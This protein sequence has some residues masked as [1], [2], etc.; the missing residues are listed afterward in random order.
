[1]TKV[2]I[3]EPDTPLMRVLGWILADAGFEVVGQHDFGEALRALPEVQPDV[4]VLNGGDALTDDERGDRIA[5]LR[6]RWPRGRVIDLTHLGSARDTR[7]PTLAD[8]TLTKP[9]HAESLVAA[10]HDLSAKGEPL[11]ET[12]PS[13][14]A[15][16]ELG[17]EGE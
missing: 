13:S 10:I 5:A 6:T 3:V 9:F 11:G 4:T 1:M 12:E 17:G 8:V 14:P 2:L 16:A 7:S 15:A